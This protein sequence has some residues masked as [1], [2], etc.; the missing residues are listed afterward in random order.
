MP[1]FKQG[2]ITV[3]LSEK[4]W[5]KR[6]EQL[7][8]KDR[9]KWKFKCPNCGNIQSPKDFRKYKDQGAKPDNVYV[10]CIGRFMKNCKGTIGNKISPCNYA[11]Y[12]LFR[13]VKTVVISKDGKEHAVFEFA[14]GETLTE[15]RQ[16]NRRRTHNKIQRTKTNKQT[17]WQKDN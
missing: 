4:E 5:S 8:G 14:E 17:K 15:L 6:G 9:L 7:F 13:F 11:L 16:N 3:K 1:E 10:D 2:N 12:G